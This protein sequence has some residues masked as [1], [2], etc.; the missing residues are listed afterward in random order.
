[1]STESYFKNSTIGSQNINVTLFNWLFYGC[2]TSE[3]KLLYQYTSTYPV[4]LF[5]T[6]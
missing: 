3:D 2:V 1:M 6:I 4:S 5:R